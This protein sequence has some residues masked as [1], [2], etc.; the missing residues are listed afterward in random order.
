MLSAAVPENIS[1]FAERDRDTRL[2]SPSSPI[3]WFFPLGPLEVWVWAKLFLLLVRGRA[4][5]M[6]GAPLSSRSCELTR[7]VLL[8]E[9]DLMSPKHTCSPHPCP[10]TRLGQEQLRCRAPGKYPLFWEQKSFCIS[11]PRRS[12]AV[13][14]SEGS[15]AGGRYGES[16]SFPGNTAGSAGG[17]CPGWSRCCVTVGA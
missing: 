14:N 9:R 15:Q 16:R 12:R 8:C 11:P 6:Q 2:L 4:E 10:G 7:G 3:L 13:L 1:A 17:G 5:D